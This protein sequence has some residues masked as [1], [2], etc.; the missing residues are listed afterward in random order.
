MVKSYFIN[1]DS[2][3]TLTNS[4]TKDIMKVIN[5]LEKR[6]ISLKGTPTK[7]ITQ[8]GRFS[9]SWAINDSWFTINEKCTH[10]IG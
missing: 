4:E 7:F 6:G 5:S 9:F 10:S 8:E 2:E 1:T 3:I